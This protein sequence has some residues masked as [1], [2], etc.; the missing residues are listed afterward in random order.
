LKKIITI[1]LVGIFLLQSFCISAKPTNTTKDLQEDLDPLVDLEITVN[2]SAIRALDPVDKYSDPDFYVKVTINNEE[3]SSPTWEDTTYQYNSWK[4]TQDVPDEEELVYITLQLFDKNVGLDKQCDISPRVN[5]EKQGLTVNLVYNVKTGHWHGDDAV[6][7]DASGY[8]RLNGCDDNNIYI[9]EDD[10]ELWFNIFQ[11]DYDN[12]NIPYWMEE[13]I[14]GT[15]PNIDNTGDDTDNDMI[16]IEWEHLWGYHPN[17][18]DDHKQLDPDHDSLSNFEEYLTSQWDSNPFRRDLF[19][20]LDY[21]E[22]SHNGEKS[23]MPNESKEILKNP[24]HRHNIVVHIDSG[25]MMCGGEI[26]PFDNKTNSE[27]VYQLYNEYFLHGDTDYWRRSIFHYGLF[28][29][30]CIPA[31]YGFS[32]ERVPFYGPG[33]NSFVISSKH[34]RE[35]SQ[36]TRKPLE[37][38]YSSAMM[39]EIG[40]SFGIRL[41]NPFGCDG[42]FT[43]YPWQIG[44]WIFRNYK[45]IMNYRFTYKILDYS[46]GSHGRRDHDDWANL[47]FSHFE[48]Q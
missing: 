3:Y 15:D 31:G 44:Y 21:M 36:K 16:P 18:W 9:E 13:N 46:D 43:K 28:V 7:G 20:E 40:H 25:E 10:C 27:G 45:S 30:D 33:T 47:D 19:L 12:D 38:V 24:Y 35:I 26:I 2:I 6:L 8:G 34:M 4:V 37:Y 32:G 42:Q 39:H 23:I 5:K 22:D 41:G 48:A 14:Y 17:I 1:L 11:N 29:F